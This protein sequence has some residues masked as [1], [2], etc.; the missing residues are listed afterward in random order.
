MLL[1]I[2]GFLG[3]VIGTV[4][5]LTG[6]GGGI[7]AVPAL[8]FGLGM[9]IREAAPVALLA[10]G[11]AALLGA[12]QGLRAGI[13]RYKAAT[14]LAIA[15]AVTAPL[16]IKLAHVLPSPWLNLI[17]A[18]VML[19][20]AYRMFISSL[21]GK[22]DAEMP[23]ELPKPCR[24]S[25][26]T[27]RFIW[28]VRTA[29]TLGGIGMISGLLTGM[30]GVGGGFVIVPALA[31]FSE[32][33]MHSIVATSLMV[34]ALLSAVTVSV[35]WGAGMSL[36]MPAL[37]FVAASLAGMAAGRVLVP[38]ISSTLLQRVFSLTCVAVAAMMLMRHAG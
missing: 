8:V 19:V 32:L 17:F 12:V 18:V 21:G 14:M 22:V 37:A 16:G 6:A 30:L 29:T 11:C 34:I 35:A 3:L 9:G 7:F 33:R 20:V 23:A 25:R 2:G 10:V 1:L 5:G 26:D 38:R 24:I 4:L 13:V 28:N 27:G 31:H 36:G 15:G